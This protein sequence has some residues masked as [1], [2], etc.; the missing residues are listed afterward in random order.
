M[1]SNRT[2]PNS[3]ANA[4]AFDTEDAANRAAFRG[5]DIQHKTDTVGGPD[6]L[7]RGVD[8]VTVAKHDKLTKKSAASDT[9][10]TKQN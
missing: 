1:S 2:L 10:P 7:I 8:R 4:S 6:E 9:A 3:K 5:Q